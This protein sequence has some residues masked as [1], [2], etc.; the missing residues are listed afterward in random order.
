M[1]GRHRAPKEPI[2]LAPAVAVVALS[3][4]AA[5][6]VSTPPAA[7]DSIVPVVPEETS[8]PATPVIQH[9]TVVPGDC[10][11]EIAQRS[12]ETT[13]QLYAENRD[14][15]GVDPNLIF[16]GQV[17]AV[18]VSS[19]VPVVPSTPAHAAPFQAPLDAMTV[20][21][22]FKGAAHQGIDLHAEIGTPGYAVADGTVLFS[23]PA[24]GFGL[25]TV[26]RSQIDGQTVDFVYGHMD[27]LLVSEGEHVA[28]GEHV[29]DTG[30]NGVVTGPHLH[31][32]V[33]IGGRLG[34]S[35]VDPVA[36]LR[37]H[38]VNV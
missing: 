11:S 12:G 3:A 20:T 13:D 1:A 19:S 10:L 14:V 5:G 33:W 17:L 2:R 9:Y 34:G 38:G 21:Q 15:V 8:S 24:S 28:V 16:P 26:I 25:W 31:F 18:G 36:W 35:P 22:A 32:E 4:A 37:A 7:A 30:T 6:T 29:I 23:R 27:H